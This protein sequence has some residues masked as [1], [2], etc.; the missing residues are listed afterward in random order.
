MVDNEPYGKLISPRDETKYHVSLTSGTHECYLELLPKDKN[1][2]VY[3]TNVLVR[4]TIA[5][6]LS[7][8]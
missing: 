7:N 4:W 1:E 2:E 6:F 3:K 5:F 8:F